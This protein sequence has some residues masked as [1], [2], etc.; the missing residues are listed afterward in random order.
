[1]ARLLHAGA[2]KESIMYELALNQRPIE[3]FHVLSFEGPDSYSR[4]GGIASR[5]TGLVDALADSAHDTHLWFVGDPDG[6]PHERR[7]HLHLHRWCQWISRHHPRGVYCGEEAKCEDYAAFLPPYLLQQV[8]LPLLAGGGR[9]VILAEEWHTAHAVLHL[10]WLLREAGLRAQVTML[11]NANNTFGFDRIDWARLDAAATLITVSRYMRQRM[12]QHGVD[13]I[14]IPNGLSPESFD[15]PDPEVGAA[16][17]HRVQHRLLL[18]KVA[19]WDPDKRWLLAVA[20]IAELKRQGAAP[21]LIARGGIEAYEREVLDR[22]RRLGLRIVERH[23]CE[24]GAAG[25]L[26][27]LEDTS[28]AD[29]VVV[30]SHLDSQARG[31][32]F[33]TADAVLANSAHEPFG[34]V[35][36]ET[37]AVGGLACTG[38][39]GEDY[40]MDGQ[41]ALVLHDDDPREFV[42]LF[43]RVRSRTGT[44][45]DMR[46]AA[47]QTAREYAWSRVVERSLLPRIHS[48]GSAERAERGRA[49]LVA[50]RAE[51]DPISAIRSHP[52]APHSDRVATRAGF[53]AGP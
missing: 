23:G 48:S 38:A 42:S 16:L 29:V 25:L 21:L 27:A 41:N 28:S 22:G 14:V 5:V 32:L 40:A 19:R 52:I 15:A 17:R 12:R 2:E 24:P 47:M 43:R 30:R 53:A 20:T 6:A 13:A 45:A 9:A 18:A 26:H 36:L 7:G 35:G 33:R 34:L 10:D 11:W 46:R 37:M 31:M 3:Q 8:L 4:A 39:S 1:V 49:S 51:T 50:S 44:E